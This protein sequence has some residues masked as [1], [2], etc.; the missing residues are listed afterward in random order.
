MDVRVVVVVEDGED[1]E[2]DGAEEG[3]E[4]GADSHAFLEARGVGCEFVVVSQPSFGEEREV[5]EDDGDAA[6][7]DEEWLE[8]ESTDI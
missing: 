5:E 1:D 8:S 6:T 3:E 7:C 4:D 2:A